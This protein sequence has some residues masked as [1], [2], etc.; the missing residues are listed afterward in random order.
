MES[1][2]SVIVP[3]Y[4]VEKYLDR[5][6]E[7]IV[8]QTYK[9][10]EIILVDDGSPDRC[11]QMC[12][13]W[14]KKDNRIKVIHKENGGLS[15][16]RNAGLEIC[17]GDYIGFVDSDDFINN[18]MY[19]TLLSCIMQKNV[20]MSI[21]NVSK[22]F[23]NSNT[24]EI[25]SIIDGLLTKDEFLDHME[26]FNGWTW[27]VSWNKLY[28]KR[29]FEELRFPVGRIYEDDYIIIDVLNYCELVYA[30]SNPLYYYYY[31]R[32]GSIVNKNYSL[33][34]M[35]AIDLFLKR[36]DYFL[37]SNEKSS[38]IQF[39]LRI[40]IVNFEKYLSSEFRAASVYN[41]YVKEYRRIF[42]KS[43]FKGKHYNLKYLLYF[44]VNSISPKLSYYLK[45][46][47]IK[48]WKK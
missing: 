25:G 16:A 23:C 33:K 9:N 46:N 14:A 4:N 32:D 47:I 44:I 48:S 24:E 18:D 26:A 43:I 12:D 40:V 36:A 37:N 11:P 42:L 28:K 8:N 39:C 3:V 7:S 34:N 13:E 10:I 21:C 22:V 35:D 45:G 27:V 19:R 31:Q 38:R 30:I 5:C 15:S 17:R 41:N 29:I 1:L 2:I 20:D 6:V